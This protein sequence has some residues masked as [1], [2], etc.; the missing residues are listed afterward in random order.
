MKLL[1]CIS[2]ILLIF[3]NYAN[4]SHLYMLYFAKSSKAGLAMSL[5]YLRVFCLQALGNMLFI[6]FQFEIACL[7]KVYF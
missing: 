6:A 3:H 4:N 5:L 2:S 7:S 1:K